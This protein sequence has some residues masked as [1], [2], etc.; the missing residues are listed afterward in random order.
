MYGLVERVTAIYLQSDLS[1]PEGLN[2]LNSLIPSNR[3][4]WKVFNSPGNRNLKETFNKLTIK[5]K[6]DNSD[7]RT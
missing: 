5:L 2:G 6:C 3:S 1:K 4:S 7:K